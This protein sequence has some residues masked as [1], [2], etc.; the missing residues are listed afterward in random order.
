[1]D[2][3]KTPAGLEL[4]VPRPGWAGKVADFDRLAFGADA[5]PLAVWRQEL[6]S[7]IAHYRAL[8]PSEPSLA[9]IPDVIAIGGV[10]EGIEAEILTIAVAPNRRGQGLGGWLLDELLAIADRQGSE[11]VFLEVRSRDEVAQALYLGRGFEIVGGRKNYYHDDDA[12]VMR[13]DRPD[14][15]SGRA[16]P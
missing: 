16:A 8:V 3:R 11:S 13:R 1:M 5:W 9:A 6:R 4:C 2:D 12:V 10:S 14:R 7:G 15:R